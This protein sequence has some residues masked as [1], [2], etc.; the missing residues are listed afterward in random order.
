MSLQNRISNL[1]MAACLIAAPLLHAQSGVQAQTVVTVMPKNGK[2]PASLT[3][4]QLKATVGDKPAQVSDF[5]PLRGE[6]SG[7]QIV[8]LIDSSARSSLSLQFSSLKSFIQKLPEGAQVGVAY[9]QNGRAAMAQNITPDRAL[10]A[11][12]LRLT[13]GV[14][15]ETG[16][17]YFCLS[18]LVKNW[19][20]GST[21]DRR[22][23][24]MITDG[25]DLYYGRRYDPND[26]YVQSA[27]TDAQRAGVIVHSIFY[28]DTGRFDGG[29]WTESGA[30]NYLLQV[31]DGTGGHAYWQG[32]GNPVSFDPFLDD[33]HTRLENQYELGLLAR[34]KNKTELQPLKLKV[35]ASGVKVDAAKMIL[36]PGSESSA[37]R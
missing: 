16:S 37:S 9:M 6:R 33:L 4:Q 7:L 20:S 11:N 21:P 18:D 29:E 12:S 28:R 8:I 31:S 22:E 23:V 26:P 32:F 30:Q 17:P 19:P 24:L 25:V 27:V 14:P 5:V 36:I 35:S 13:S 2:Q 3:A 10:A 1:L 34:P 15:G